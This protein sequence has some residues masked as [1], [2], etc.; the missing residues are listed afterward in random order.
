M[1][2]K[3]INIC[4]NGPYI[5]THT[6]FTLPPRTLAILN[7]VLLELREILYDHTYK[8]KPNSFITD[9]DEVAIP[10]INIS[11]KQTAFSICL[12]QSVIDIYLLS[13][14][15]FRL[16]GQNRYRHLWNCHWNSQWTLK[17]KVTSGQSAKVSQRIVHLLSCWYFSAPKCRPTRF[18]SHWWNQ[19]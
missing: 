13:K 17:L 6:N 1:L 19:K 4:R 11:S 14:N 12:S 9:P 7:N 16:C 10:A 15:E 18:S 8:V 5:F 2:V 3:T